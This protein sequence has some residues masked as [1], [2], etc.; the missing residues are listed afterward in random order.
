MDHVKLFDDPPQKGY[1]LNFPLVWQFWI[2]EEMIIIAF[3]L[4]FE[5]TKQKAGHPCH[6][7]RAKLK[8]MTLEKPSRSICWRRTVRE[9][10][11]ESAH[12]FGAELASQ[13]LASH[14]PVVHDDVL[15]V[16]AATDWGEEKWEDL[17]KLDY[18]SV[19]FEIL[20]LIWGYQTKIVHLS[21]PWSI[22]LAE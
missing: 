19:Y 18:R 6:V 3:S 8:K 14:M 9:M 16:C 2:C 12:F 15:P 20:I 10:T 21:R 1:F 11:R 5:I 22:A 13:T 17:C 4:N 7:T